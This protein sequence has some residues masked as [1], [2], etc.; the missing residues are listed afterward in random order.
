M[1]KYLK[2]EQMAPY[3]VK[4]V[5]SFMGREGYGFNCTLYRNGKRV[6]TCIDDAGGGG[7]YPVDWLRTINAKAEQALLDAHVKTLPPVD[8]DFGGDPL[9][10]DAGWFVTELVNEFEHAKE[11]RKLKRQCE[12]KTLYRV[13]TDKEGSY[14]VWKRPFDE[15]TRNIIVKKFGEDVEIFNEVFEKGG[16]PSTMAF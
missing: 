13:P 16:V 6:A 15:A 14:Y 11:V 10:M 3:A 9:T 4:N 8:S 1:S 2:P 12:T 7:M 5:K